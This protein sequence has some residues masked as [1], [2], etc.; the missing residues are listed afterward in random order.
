M[1]HNIKALFNFDPPAS[2]QEIRAA[3]AQF[4]RK[5]SGSTRPSRANLAACERATDEISAVVGELLATLVTR[6]KPKDR[7]IKSAS[8]RA[9]KR[10][11]G[12]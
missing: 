11:A 1:C 7:A 2:E 3:A 6:A 10:F 5:I 8:V 4:V 12:E 9:S